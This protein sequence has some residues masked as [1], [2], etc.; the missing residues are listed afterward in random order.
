[1]SKKNKKILTMTT[2]QLN[3]CFAGCGG[4][5]DGVLKQ[6]AGTISG[7]DGFWVVIPLDEDHEFDPEHPWWHEPICEGPWETREEAEFFIDAEVGCEKVRVVE[8][9]GGKA[10][11]NPFEK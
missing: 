4:A 2:D 9:R 10:V 7:P 3:K 8:V 5:D 11:N 1:M 6:I